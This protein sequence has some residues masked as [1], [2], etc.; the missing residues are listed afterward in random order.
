MPGPL[1]PTPPPPRVMASDTSASYE[2][3]AS[4]GPSLILVREV[5]GRDE[6]AIALAMRHG[7][8]P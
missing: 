1:L 7:E 2:S 3:S 5:P 8:Q 4:P 6:L